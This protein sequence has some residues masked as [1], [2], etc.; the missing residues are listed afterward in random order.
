VTWRQEQPGTRKDTLQLE[1]VNVLVGIDER[2]EHAVVDVERRH[3][4][5]DFAHGSRSSPSSGWSARR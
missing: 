2:I 4:P 3:S 1:L 5:D